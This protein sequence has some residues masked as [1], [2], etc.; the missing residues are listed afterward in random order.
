M[1]PVVCYVRTSR[2]KDSETNPEKLDQSPSRPVVVSRS[3]V[4]NEWYYS[5]ADPV[6]PTQEVRNGGAR[7]PAPRPHGW[8]PKRKGGFTMVSP[9]SRFRNRLQF[10]MFFSQ[11]FTSTLKITEGLTSLRYP[12]CLMVQ[13][14]P[15]A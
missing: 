13:K 8:Q 5:N 6:D 4:M 12:L 9:W 10:C 15:S 1:N 3:Q 7:L 2:T 14:S 11:L